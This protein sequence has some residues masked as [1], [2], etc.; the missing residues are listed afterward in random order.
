MD[1]PMLTSLNL[2][3]NS[4]EG[5][6]P[7]LNIANLEELYLDSNSFTGVSSGLHFSMLNFLD[8]PIIS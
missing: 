4:L 2:T 1:F 3:N 6:I 5:A 7:N 8:L